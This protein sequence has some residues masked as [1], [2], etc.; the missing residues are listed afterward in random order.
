MKPL[1]NLRVVVSLDDHTITCLMAA[2]Y[3]NNRQNQRDGRQLGS[4]GAPAEAALWKKLQRKQLGGL[5]FHRQYALGPYVLD[6]YCADKLLAIE[7]DGTGPTDPGRVDYEAKRSAYL[8]D[9][10]IQ[11]LR[12]DKRRIFAKIDEVLAAITEAAVTS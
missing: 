11:V 5:K 10:G 3:P 2:S 6:Y 12:I 9:R 1:L 4:R 7:L 8:S